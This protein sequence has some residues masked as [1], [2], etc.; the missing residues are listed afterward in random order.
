MFSALRPHQWL[1]NGLVALPAIA[2][3]AFNRPS[4]FAVI[5]AFVSMSAAASAFYIFNDLMD[6]E[7]DRAHPTKKMRAIASGRLRPPAAVLV[8]V[9]LVLL[10]TGFARLL[11]VGFGVALLVYVIITLAY[12]AKLKHELMADVVVLALLYGIRVVA[13]ATATHTPLSNW[14][15]GFC[16]FVFLCLALLKRVAEAANHGELQGRAYVFADAP[17]LVS[18]AMASGFMSIAMLALYINSSDVT[19]FYAHPDW[20]WGIC[21]VLTFWLGRSCLLSCRGEMG[22]DPVLFAATDVISLLSAALI[23]GVFLCSWL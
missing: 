5:Y 10:S 9:G 19:R 6:V 17:T 7:H 2:D 4:F 3:H 12:S 15:I 22:D 13:G 23:V 21:L 14:M 1:K 11:P 8:G 18:L 20:L 16:Y